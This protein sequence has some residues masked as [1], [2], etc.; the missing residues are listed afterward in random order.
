MIYCICKKITESRKIEKLESKFWLR[1]YILQTVIAVL[2]IYLGGEYMVHGI[3][4]L[5]T[6]FNIDQTAL[7]V[8]LVP[9]ATVIPESIVG[10]IF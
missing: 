9:I 5:G 1:N 2:A 6:V 3:I 8:I 4:E 10:L 7:T